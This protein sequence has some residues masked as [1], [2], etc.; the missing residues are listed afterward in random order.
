[1][2]RDVKPANVILGPDGPRLIDLGVV[3]TIDA[4][5]LTLTGQPVGTPMYMT[6]EQA[7]GSRAT[8]SADVWA[9]GALAYYAA[10]GNRLFSGDHPAVVL[11][12]VSAEAPSYDDCPAYLR[13]FLEACLVRDP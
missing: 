13:P 11:Y 5:R 7:A 1:M 3:A 10:T 8:A 4:T 12:R 2:H 6:P 9:L